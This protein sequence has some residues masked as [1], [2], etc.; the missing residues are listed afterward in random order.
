MHIYPNAYYNYRKKRKENY[1]KDKEK[2]KQA[3]LEIYH[4]YSGRPGHRMMV[5]YLKRKNIQLS[6]T[7]VLKYMKELGLR[8][9]VVQKKSVS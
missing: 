6:K 5:I 4:T 3:I 9:V 7:T 1:H 2:K 8:S